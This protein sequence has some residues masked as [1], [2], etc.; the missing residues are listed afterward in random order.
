MILP[1]R[2]LTSSEFKWISATLL[3]LLTIVAIYY[4]HWHEKAKNTTHFNCQSDDVTIKGV[5]K[6]TK[7]I[8]ITSIFQIRQR[9][10]IGDIK[11]LE[12]GKELVTLSMDSH[13]PN[14][15][16]N[17]ED[18]LSWTYGTWGQRLGK[19]IA[20]EKLMDWNL[21]LK[22]WKMKTV[23]KEGQTIWKDNN[24][25]KEGITEINWTCKWRDHSPFRT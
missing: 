5:K 12:D 11:I 19:G 1:R 2:K 24:F 14:I 8:P 10:D 23:I 21:N 17:S 4:Y 3:L 20:G 16:D 9:Q 15:S 25:V 13:S 18:N 7:D 22:T 6:K